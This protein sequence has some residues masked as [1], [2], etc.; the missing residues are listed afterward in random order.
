MTDAEK[1]CSFI[2]LQ[3]KDGFSPGKTCKRREKNRDAARKS[4]KKQTERAD[5]LHEVSIADILCYLFNCDV[6]YLTDMPQDR[7]PDM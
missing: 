6:S 7:L 4:R 5:I 3:G 2:L 1:T